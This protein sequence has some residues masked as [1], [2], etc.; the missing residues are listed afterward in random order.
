MVAIYLSKL[1]K[2][3]WTVMPHYI[4]GLV[5]ITIRIN[6][7]YMTE[8]QIRV[9]GFLLYSSRFLRRQCTG[10]IESNK[11]GKVHKGASLADWV[12]EGT[13]YLMRYEAT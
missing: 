5:F 1:H 6:K 7:S 10:C 12:L 2:V 13:T 4:L 3:K 11:T 8:C 9:V